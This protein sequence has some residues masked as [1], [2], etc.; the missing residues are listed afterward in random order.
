M[1]I[2]AAY[3][4]AVLITVSL[5]VIDLS[6]RYTEVQVLSVQRES[7]ISDACKVIT[8]FSSVRSLES[9]AIALDAERLAAASSARCSSSRAADTPSTSCAACSC[10]RH[11]GH[12]FLWFNSAMMQTLQHN[13]VNSGGAIEGGASDMPH[14]S[15]TLKGLTL[16]PA[17]L[18]VQMLGVRTEMEMGNNEHTVGCH[19]V[20]C[21]KLHPPAEPVQARKPT[22]PL[23]FIEADG[24]IVGRAHQIAVHFFGP[25]QPPSSNI[26]HSNILHQCQHRMSIVE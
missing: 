7:E 3:Q 4:Q 26:G 22:G 15:N 16:T 19:A 13:T 20:P 24:A 11:S 2:F 8:S 5:F 25:L 12:L 23:H 10:M 17:P 18:K 9:H 21:R 14:E 6:L 1:E